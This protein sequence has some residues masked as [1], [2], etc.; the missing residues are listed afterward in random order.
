MAGLGG[1]TPQQTTSQVPAN[2]NQVIAN[3]INPGSGGSSLGRA[4]APNFGAM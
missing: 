1:S 2:T 4:P 3:L